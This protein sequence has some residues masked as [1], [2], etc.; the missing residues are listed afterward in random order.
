[1]YS[2]HQCYPTLQTGAIAPAVD[3]LLWFQLLGL[4]VVVVLL[5]LV[6]LLFFFF[7]FPHSGHHSSEKKNLDLGNLSKHG[8]KMWILLFFAHMNIGTCYYFSCA[9]FSDVRIW[10]GLS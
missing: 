3:A 6:L 2:I 8:N 5:Q 10:V 7:F 1:V 4:V 9:Q